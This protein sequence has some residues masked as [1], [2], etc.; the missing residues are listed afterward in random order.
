[1][2]KSTENKT[3]K[4]NEMGRCPSTVCIS[5]VSIVREEASIHILNGKSQF[6][7]TRTGSGMSILGLL[8]GIVSYERNVLE[9]TSQKL[10]DSRKVLDSKP[11]VESRGEER[12]T[13]SGDLDG[14]KFLMALI[15]E[16]T[17]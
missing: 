15:F 12:R 11:V 7:N 10:N 5:S 13:C 6:R 8:F 14:G 3:S 4:S 17:V 2:L 1:M 16:S 9:M